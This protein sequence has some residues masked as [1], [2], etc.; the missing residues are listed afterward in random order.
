MNAIYVHMKVVNLLEKIVPST[1]IVILFE[2][3][4]SLLVPC[5]TNTKPKHYNGPIEYTRTY[6]EFTHSIRIWNVMPFPEY[7]K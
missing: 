2:L 3:R 4:N 1:L 5:M 6:I 7:G